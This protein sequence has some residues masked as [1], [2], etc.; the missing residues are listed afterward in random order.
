[1]S[2]FA[3][4]HEGRVVA[5][6]IR[7]PLPTSF[8]GVLI[9]ETFDLEPVAIW[10]EIA[11]EGPVVIDTS[12]GVPTGVRHTWSVRQ[13][14]I[15]ERRREW[16]SHDFDSRV[17]LLSPGAW[18]RLEAAARNEGFPEELRAKLRTAIRQSDKAVSV[19]SDDPDTL[20]FFGAAVSV[21]VLT[22]QQADLILNGP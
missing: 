8:D 9:P 21:G 12:D 4:V 14:T 17:E 10:P 13:R 1:M 3:I 19:I 7:E 6:G 18:D 5:T 15:E 11:V 20:Q 2:T 16:S 22:D